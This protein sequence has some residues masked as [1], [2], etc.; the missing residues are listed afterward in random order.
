MRRSF[1]V[2]Y[3]CACACSHDAAMQTPDPAQETA[4]QDSDP[5]PD[6]CPTDPGADRR[7]VVPVGNF[8]SMSIPEGERFEHSAVDPVSIWV[9]RLAPGTRLQLAVAFDARFRPDAPAAYEIVVEGGADADPLEAATGA[10]VPVEAR[11][12]ATVESEFG[13]FV[14][15]TATWV[16]PEASRLPTCVSMVL[17]VPDDADADPES[18][19]AIEQVTVRTSST[20]P[21]PPW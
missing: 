7:I 21:D 1:A 3:A 9:S 6:P 17:T 2:L 8:A 16:L 14:D 4:L 15:L 10:S 13:F 19:F 20:D 11:T 12:M 18:T 5:P